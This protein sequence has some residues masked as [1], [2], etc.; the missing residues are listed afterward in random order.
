MTIFIQKNGRVEIVIDSRNILNKVLILTF[1][2]SLP[3][4]KAATK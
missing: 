4:N 2:F 1:Y 3:S